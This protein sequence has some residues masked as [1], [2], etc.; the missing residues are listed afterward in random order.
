MLLVRVLTLVKPALAGG[1]A[2]AAVAGGVIAFDRWGDEGPTPFAALQSQGEQLIISEFGRDADTIVAVDPADPNTRS[3]IATIEHADSYG[4]FATLSPDGEAIAYTALPSDSQ[5]P[6]PAAPAHAGIVDVDGD[7]QVLATDI[8]LLVAPVWAPDSSAI[9]V[10][11]NTPVEDSAGAFELLLLGRDG[12][13]AT[14]T[15][16]RSAAVFPIAFSADGSALYFATLNASGSNLYRVAADGS[17]ET[18]IAHLT[19]GIARDWKL[20]P[21]GASIAYS[22]AE[23]ENPVVRT[24]R[25]DVASG[26]ISDAVARDGGDEFNPAWRPDGAL[27]VAAL[28][29]DGAAALSVADGGGNSE[30]TPASTEEIDLPLTWSP[31]GEHLAVRA[32]DG[33]S[34]HDAGESHVV[35]VDAQGARQRVSD[36][37]DVLIVGWL[38]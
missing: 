20:S 21:D 7:A 11:K 15:S 34:A 6:S 22:V 36:A 35:L 38:E 27:T 18:L 1:I 33:T 19:D 28:G 3:E 12:S 16:W 9:V 29:D 26:A 24:M 13:R 17:D 4:V 25:L 5:S 31:D 32:V 14:I 8:D 2:A 30:V 23:V 10:R 37:P